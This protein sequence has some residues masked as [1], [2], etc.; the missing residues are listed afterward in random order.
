[1]L[2]RPADTPQEARRLLLNILSERGRVRPWDLVVSRAYFYQLRHGLRPIP[3]HILI[4]LLELAR[5][6][7]WRL[8]LLGVFCWR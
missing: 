2:P 6:G 4:K 3:D 8:A 5:G 7:F 1:M